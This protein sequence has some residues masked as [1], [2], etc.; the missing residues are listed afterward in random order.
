MVDL[1]GLFDLIPPEI[2]ATVKVFRATETGGDAGTPV[3][4]WAETLEVQMQIE[5]LTEGQAQRQFG[6]ETTSRWRATA[7]PGLD[8][9]PNDLL[10]I[11]DGPYAGQ[12]LLVRDDREPMKGALRIIRADDTTETP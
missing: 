9:K 8:I 12:N 4:A 6:L 11:Q 10:Q 1:S 5:N 7:E 3:H 2:L